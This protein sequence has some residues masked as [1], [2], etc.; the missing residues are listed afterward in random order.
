MSKKKSE[1]DNFLHFL[2]KLF[3]LVNCNNILTNFGCKQFLLGTKMN[4]KGTTYRTDPMYLINVS[5][6]Q[7]A[8]RIKCIAWRH[9]K[10]P[11]IRRG[12]K[13][14]NDSSSICV[15]IHNTFKDNVLITMKQ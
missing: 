6:I 13:S 7:F 10:L 5:E 3:S 2:L 1:Y 14:K 4:L 9:F 11:K 15:Y 8:F 12:S